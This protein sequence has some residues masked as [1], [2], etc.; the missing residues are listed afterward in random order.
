MVLMVTSWPG[1]VVPEREVLEYV[2]ECR[3][4]EWANFRVLA[5]LPRPLTPRERRDWERTL[6]KLRAYDRILT[7]FPVSPPLART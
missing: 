2:A 3:R 7:R 6:G 5:G 4:A 1:C